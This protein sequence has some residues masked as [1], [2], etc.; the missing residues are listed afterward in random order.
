M[1]RFLPDI[2]AIAWIWL[3]HALVFLL[4]HLWDIELPGLLLLAFFLLAYT[5]TGIRV[6][7][8][9]AKAQRRKLFWT[10]TLSL[11]LGMTAWDLS[12]WAFYHWVEPDAKSRQVEQAM[13]RWQERFRQRGRTVSPE[14]IEAQRENFLASYEQP[15]RISSVGGN[16]FMAFVIGGICMGVAPA[17]DGKNS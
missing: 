17:L 16:L 10:I 1:R 3:A 2:E 14:E 4:N 11:F 15:L 7:Y 5:A 12:R 8:R 6:L 13:E 9:S